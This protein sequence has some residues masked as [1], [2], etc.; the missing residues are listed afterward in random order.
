MAQYSATRGAHGDWHRVHLGGLANSGAGLV[1]IEMTAPTCDGRCS[2][3]DCSLHDDETEAALAATVALMK[4]VGPARVG[5]QIGHGGRKASMHA[6]WKGGAA[7]TPEEGA[8]ETMA[9]SPLAFGAGP[10]PREMTQGDI[11]AL[12][13]AHADAAARAARAGVDLIEIHA[14]HG[15]LLHQ[16][17]SPVT[18][19]RED[20]YGGSRE[21]R[22]RLLIEVLEATRAAAPG[23]PVGMRITASD[24]IE[25]GLTPPD[26]VALAKALEA[27]GCAFVDVTSG[28]IDPAQKIAVGPLYQVDFAA[29]VK[30]AVAIPVRAVGL[31]ATPEQA[32]EIVATGKA[33]QVALARA[34]LSNPRWGWWAAYRL[35]AVPA[36][37]PQALR[38]AHPLWAGWRMIDPAIPA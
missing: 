25:G 9:P 26:A 23:L 38:A 13:A 30:A 21:N 29:A 6:P 1:M 15:Y 24:W 8:W 35:G 10:V 22:M 32:E 19:R 18:N 28:G 7:L 3:G 36:V 34:F 20:A 5:I 4:A 27:A 14:A 12:I 37:P 17:H 11:R 16:F 31:I 33:D 2:H